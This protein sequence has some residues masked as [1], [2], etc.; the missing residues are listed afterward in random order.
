[1]LTVITL[2]M[3]MQGLTAQV[4]RIAQITEHYPAIYRGSVDVRYFN[5]SEVD[6]TYKLMIDLPHSYD[7]SDEKLYPI[8][9]LTDAYATAGIAQ[10]TFDALTMDHTIPEVIV[11]GIDYPYTNMTQLQRY[12]FRDMMPTHIEGYEPSGDADKFINFIEKELF[13]YMQNNYHVD[14]TDRAFFGHSAAG[15]FGSHILLEKPYL[16]NRYVIGSPVYQWD[17]KEMIKRIEGMEKV[18]G[19]SEIVIY[20]YIGGNEG[21]VMLN[22]WNTFNNLLKEKTGSK[23][24]V[25]DQIY[26]DEGHYSVGLTAFSKAIRFIYTYEAQ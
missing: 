20:S 2:F 8:M 10:T 11:I 12:R 5:S 15:L 1:M 7:E 3:A 9:I 26:K 6:C 23:N 18:G 25:E 4:D 24:H 17:D 22:N 19:N 21:D 13:P 16:F 14:T